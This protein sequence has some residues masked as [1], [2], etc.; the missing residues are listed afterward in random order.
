MDEV[1]SMDSPPDLE[2]I[3]LGSFDAD[4]EQEE[5]V[6]PVAKTFVLTNRPTV[7]MVTVKKEVKF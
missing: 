2:S 1:H 3:K 7:K 5:E 6:K 4:D